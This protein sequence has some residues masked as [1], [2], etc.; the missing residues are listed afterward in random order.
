MPN[1]NKVFT[2]IAISCMRANKDNIEGF[3]KA[4]RINNMN[5]VKRSLIMLYDGVQGR[6]KCL[7]HIVILYYHRDR[8]WQLIFIYQYFFSIKKVSILYNIYNL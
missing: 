1:N 3:M 7:L 5:S 6:L 2:V 8:N 4:S